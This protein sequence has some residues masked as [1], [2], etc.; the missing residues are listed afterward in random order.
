MWPQSVRITPS[1]PVST[2][3][4]CYGSTSGSNPARVG[5]IPTRS[6]NFEMPNKG[7]QK[8]TAAV[9]T[10]APCQRE[11]SIM[12]ILAG[13]LAVLLLA[14]TTQAKGVK[15]LKGF[16]AKVYNG[17]LALYA[18][19]KSLD[20]TDRFIC[21][22]QVIEK[23]DG[24]Y[25][26]L[27]AGHCTPANSE[28]LPG[29]MTFKVSEDLGQPL[30]PVT[31]IAAKMDEPVDWAI[32]YFPTK[33]KYSV[34]HLGDESDVR[35]NS[36]TIDVNFSLALAKEVS[37]GVVS[38]TV[39]T[40]GHA[41]GFFEVTQFDS[42]GASGSSVVSEST[43]KVIGIVIAGVDGT[44]TPTW[45]EPASV[46]SKQIAGIDVTQ[47][48]PYI[49]APK[50]MFDFSHPNLPADIWQHGHNNHEQHNRPEGNHSRDTRTLNRDTHH[51]FDGRRDHN[52]RVEISFE[53]YWFGCGYSWPYW[54]FEGDI[55]FVE[56]PN[57][58]FFVYNY[59]NP[60]LMVQVSL[61]E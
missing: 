30:M 5:S 16:D 35:L 3:C 27:S 23:V 36:K 44:T 43:K 4:K 17:S 51:R 19:S 1:P 32:Y 61:V 22:T 28:E 40:Q 21:S 42:H 57:G 47:N 8:G 59:A 12:R 49:A 39:Q 29:D 14:S 15:P 53:G 50:T 18:S 2:D 38:S 58:V 52:G 6:A 7:S 9:M 45:V 54:V 41:K 11:R 46:I 55:Y 56:G 60:A 34:T 48:V 31:L 33:K 13:L 37:M 24:G 20:I 26:L 10:H 25:E